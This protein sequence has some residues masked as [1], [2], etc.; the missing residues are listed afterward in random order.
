LHLAI[1][2]TRKTLPFE[3]PAIALLPDHLHV[4]WTLPE[5]DAN[6]PRRWAK[7]KGVF[8]RNYL[9]AGGSEGEMT[10]NRAAHGERAV[11]QHR[12]WEHTI[13]DEDDF[14]RCVDYIHFNPVKHGLVE[15]VRDWP[16]SSFHRWA[17]AGLYEPDWGEGPSIRDVPGAEWE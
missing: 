10:A 8:T 6:Y 13:R 1:E 5:Q 16:H 7:L 9:A 14:A 11:W 15:R 17:E 12:Y 2:E 4:I 3:M